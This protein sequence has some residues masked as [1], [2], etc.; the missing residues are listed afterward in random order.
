VKR[1]TG[2]GGRSLYLPLRIA[3]T[4]RASGPELAALL[5]LMGRERVERA[6]TIPRTTP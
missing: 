4:G 2:R 5:P 3:L 1:R 6:R